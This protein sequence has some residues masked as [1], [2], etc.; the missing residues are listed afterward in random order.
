LVGV[1]KNHLVGVHK[2]PTTNFGWF[3]PRYLIYHAD[4]KI[5]P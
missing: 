3:C 2:K 5:L 4:I 1:H